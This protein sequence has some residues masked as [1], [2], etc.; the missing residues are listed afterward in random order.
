MAELDP[1]PFA[2]DPSDEGHHPPGDDPLWNESWYF[3]FV[4]ADGSLGGYVR[5]GRY[6]NLGV[7]WY[8]AC[9]VGATDRWWR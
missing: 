9:L 8:W 5:L 3:D 1:S 7:V 4:T 2:V 6:P